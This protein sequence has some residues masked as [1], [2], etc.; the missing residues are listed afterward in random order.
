[1]D[2]LKD[3][4]AAA[5]AAPPELQIMATKMLRGT[6]NIEDRAI[7]PWLTRVELGRETNLH[8]ATLWR[9]KVPGVDL[10]GRLRFK[11]SVVEAYLKSPEFKKR[12]NDLRL[13]RKDRRNQKQ[14]VEAKP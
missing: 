10:G 6:R 3:L 13:D 7:E 1:M 8:P 9:W 2:E 12:M 4:M 14:I 5:V 11:R